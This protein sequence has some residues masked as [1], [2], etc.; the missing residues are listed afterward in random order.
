MWPGRR[1]LGMENP[2]SV[3]VSRQHQWG[4]CA[5]V[6]GLGVPVL[7]GLFCGEKKSERS[8]LFFA[9]KKSCILSSLY[10]SGTHKYVRR[11]TNRTRIFGHTDPRIKKSFRNPCVCVSVCVCCALYLGHVLPSRGASRAWN[12]KR[13]EP[14]VG[15]KL[16]RPAD[17]FGFV[18]RALL[19]E[20]GPPLSSI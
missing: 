17:T 6:G 7:G 11:C 15:S 1:K 14:P 5:R 19:A 18:L 8:E 12:G 2:G 10:Y 16:V 13:K 4:M 9:A 3:G 20:L